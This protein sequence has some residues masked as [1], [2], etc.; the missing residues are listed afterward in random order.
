LIFL[1]RLTPIVIGSLLGDSSPSESK[2]SRKGRSRLTSK[3]IFSSAESWKLNASTQFSGTS[4]FAR[5]GAREFA[6]GG[7]LGS[8]F[9]QGPGAF[10]TEPLVAVAGVIADSLLILLDELGVVHGAKPADQDG[11]G[12]LVQFGGECHGSETMEIGGR[13]RPRIF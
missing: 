3:S 1:R 8:L 10:L 4:N 7:E 5:S 12:F 9:M 2:G 13:F 6:G 11:F